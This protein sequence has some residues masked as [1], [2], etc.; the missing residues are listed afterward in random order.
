MKFQK[1]SVQKLWQEK[2]MMFDKV[3]A[4]YLIS[5]LKEEL[6]KEAK[7]L[8]HG[9]N[10]A[11]TVQMKGLQVAQSEI[12]SFRIEVV[13][14]NVVNTSDRDRMSIHTQLQAKITEGREHDWNVTGRCVYTQQPLTNLP[15]LET[16]P[17]DLG[18][19]F[20]AGESCHN[21]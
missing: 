20:T 7:R 4:I 14:R 5:V 9:K 2:A 13:E 3:K 17:R 1:P 10:E 8:A 11:L 16:I 19:V 12:E 15:P 6:V 21:C 18:A